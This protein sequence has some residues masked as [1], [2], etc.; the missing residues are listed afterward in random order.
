MLTPR[1]LRCV[2]GSAGQARRVHEAAAGRIGAA[3][4]HQH[5]PT[6]VGAG[7]AIGFGQ[8]DVL[9]VPR[10]VRCVR[11]EGTW[12]FA[13]YVWKSSNEWFDGGRIAHPILST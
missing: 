11:A 10:Q 2:R 9:D 13:Q 5:Q 12:C 7:R 8:R 1:G 3:I 6:N 4:L